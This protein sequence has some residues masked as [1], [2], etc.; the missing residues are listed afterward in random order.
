MEHERNTQMKTLG[1][2]KIPSYVPIYDRLYT[3]IM[4]GVYEPG[5]RLPG[6]AA[7]AGKYHVSRNTLRQALTVLVEDGLVTKIQG[8]GTFV[9]YDGRREQEDHGLYNPM[10]T[11]SRSRIDKVDV[12]YNFG[13]ATEVGQRKLGLR[14][15]EIVLAGNSV[16]HAKGKP[17]G[18]S[19]MQIPVKHI[20]NLN[21]DLGKEED[22]RE[23]INHHIF[24]VSASV[25]MS[26]KLIY[27]E[28]YITNYLKVSRETPLIF[29]EEIFYNKEKEA[30]SRGKFY[31][32]PDEY[33]I[34]F[35]D[36]E[37]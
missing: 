34:V 3:D 16:F 37:T 7:L 13:P 6:E 27:A 15:S 19:F 28:D 14:P 35:Q 24:E 26:I 2:S 9:T 4:D 29:I 23:V 30:V 20:E 25:K 8:K 18:H 17:V 32:L 12:Y 22:V 31:F 21:V 36:K 11:C 5:S 10:I 1:N 33:D